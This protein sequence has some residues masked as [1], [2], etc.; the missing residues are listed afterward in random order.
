[1]RKQTIHVSVGDMNKK[2]ISDWYKNIGRKGAKK[3]RQ[4]MTAK[5]L[6]DHGKMMVKARLDKKLSTPLSAK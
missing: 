5:Q 4:N 6:S 3:S 2:V 1:M